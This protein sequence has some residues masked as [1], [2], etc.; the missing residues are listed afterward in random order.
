MLQLTNS[1]VAT[2][3]MRSVVLAFL[4]AGLMAGPALAQ[5]GSPSPKPKSKAQTEAKAPKKSL[6]AA[7][8]ISNSPYPSYDNDTARRISAAMLS[9]ST[10][11]VRGGWPTAAAGRREARA[12]RVRTR[13]GAAAR[14][15]RHHRR[16]CA[17]ARRRR[18]L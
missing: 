1:R 3:S 14:A 4:A 6:P 2:V 8:R 12:R 9:Y 16:S 11:E 5:T 10:L 18:R 13:G 15:P 7:T 17:P